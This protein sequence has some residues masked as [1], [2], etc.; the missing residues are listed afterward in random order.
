M[1]KK[2]PLNRNKFFH[3]NEYFICKIILSKQ[4][5]RIMSC[6]LVSLIIKNCNSDKKDFKMDRHVSYFSPCFE[7]TPYDK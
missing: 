1:K 3:L 6:K 4:H 7:N 5:F 2:A